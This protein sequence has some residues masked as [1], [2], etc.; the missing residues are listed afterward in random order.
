[1]SADARRECRPQ[2]AAGLKAA[3]SAVKVLKKTRF[4][5][6]DFL[7]G[8]RRRA[9]FDVVLCLSVTKWVHFNRGDEGVRELFRRVRHALHPGGVFVLEP[10]PWRSYRQVLKKQA[11]L[12]Y[13][14]PTALAS[15]TNTAVSEPEHVHREAS[16][17][18]ANAANIG[19][20]ADGGAML[21]ETVAA[22]PFKELSAF[23][24][25]PAAFAAHLTGEL[26]FELLAERSIGDAAKGFDRPLLVFRK[27][28]AEAQPGA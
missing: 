15:P 6:R 11:R 21:Q 9:R 5:H 1:M 18:G 2:H 3:R 17:P 20:S 27:P 28:Q 10:Q 7:E 24:L 25:R 16:L 8:G 12:P 19:K 23:Q 4:E 22:L 14:T 13:L 26:G